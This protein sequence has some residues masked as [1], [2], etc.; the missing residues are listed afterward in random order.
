ML[1]PLRKYRGV[2]AETVAAAMIQ[3]ATDNQPGIRF[4]ESDEI[5]KYQ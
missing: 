2:K 1:G 4:L 3:M 5:Q